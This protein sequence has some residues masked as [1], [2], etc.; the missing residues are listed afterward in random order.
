[1]EKA[2]AVIIIPARY[3]ST[4]FPGKPLAKICGRE[5]ILWT[6]FAA[7]EVPGIAD[8]FVATDDVRIQCIVEA[9]GGDVIM[10]SEWCRNGTER[11][12]EAASILGLSEEDIVVNF[13]GDA[14]LIPPWF[15][16]D[17]VDAMQANPDADMTTPVLRCDSHSYELFLED[18][19]NGKVGGTTVV[20]GNDMKA[21]YFSKEVIPYLAHPQE[22]GRT[23][24]F[25]HVGLYAYRV[26]TLRL[27]PSMPIGNLERAEQ[28]EQ[29]RFIENGKNVYVV[30]VNAEGRE[31][32]ELNNPEDIERIEAILK[33]RSGSQTRPL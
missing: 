7:R 22:L 1:M 9:A 10:T 32:W 25:H 12:A 16:N 14:P 15:V 24:V 19:R 23:P 21:I 3:K 28:L 8:V 33:S 30:E 4:R 5:N 2:Q 6:Y 20:F 13:Q 26:K 17:I 31:F 29:L 27:Y 18:R 11:V